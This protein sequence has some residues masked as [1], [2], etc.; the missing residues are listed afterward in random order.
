LPDGATLVP[1]ICASDVT[2]ST[3]FTGREKAWSTYMTIGNI[4][5]KTRNKAS[6]H[7]TVLFTSPAPAQMI[8]INNEILGDL[9]EAIFAPMVALGDSGIEVKCANGKVRLSFPRLAAWIADHLDNV[10][11]HGIQQNQ[12]TVCEVRPEQLG[13]HLRR[14]A[15][16]RDYR[17]YENLFQKRCDY[18]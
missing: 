2:F 10:T 5:S 12:C 13:S 3:N 6:K 18:D 7:A 1:I 17:K 15:A 11:L 4:L 16:K 14:C 9:T 8:G